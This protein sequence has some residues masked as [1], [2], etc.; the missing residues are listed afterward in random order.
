MLKVAFMVHPLPYGLYTV[1][2]NLRWPMARHGVELRWVGLGEPAAAAFDDPAWAAERAHGEVVATRRTGD[3]QQARLLADHIAGRYDAVLHSPPYYALETNLLRY[4]PRRILRFLTVQSM[5]LGIYRP[6][7]AIRQFTHLAVASSKRVGD[8]LARY[9][10]FPNERT[11]VIPNG[12]DPAPY[13]NFPPRPASPPLRLLYLGRIENN[14]KGV[15]SLPTLMEQLRDVDATLTVAGG[16]PDLEELKAR[17]A[18]LGDRVRF[19]GVL[20]PADVPDCLASHHAMV[21]FSRSEGLPN[22]LLEAMAAGC[23]PLVSRIRGLT[24]WVVTHE[25]DALLFPVGDVPEAARLASRLAAEPQLNARLSANVKET[26]RE[27]FTA[28]AVAQQYA[29]AMLKVAA[30]PPP[31]EDP[32]PIERWSYPRVFKPT[33]IQRLLSRETKNRIQQ[34]LG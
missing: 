8:D 23:V 18:P 34:W 17:C 14:Q 21:M 29:G 19:A 9:A 24:D 11:I 27:R 28:E 5:A 3:A 12:I 10:R 4:L 13:T 31:I 22:V 2:R 15:F 7:T 16:G 25:K 33:L 30:D 20:P 6:I 32:L 1:Y 26:F